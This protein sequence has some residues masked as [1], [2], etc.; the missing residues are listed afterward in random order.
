MKARYFLTKDISSLSSHERDLGL[1]FQNY[2][3]FPHLT[4]ERNIA[5][6]LQKASYRKAK[7]R[8]KIAGVATDLGINNLL[9]RKPSEL[10]GGQRQRVRACPITGTKPIYSSAG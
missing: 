4:V 10:S 7:K 1:V 3:L 9:Q 5:I 8:K 6:G 2:A